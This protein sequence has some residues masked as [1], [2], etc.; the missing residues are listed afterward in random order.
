MRK[1]PKTDNAIHY[2]AHR[3]DFVKLCGEIERENTDLREQLL[4]ADQR[5]KLLG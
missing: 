5:I 4:F 3:T 1:T 2:L